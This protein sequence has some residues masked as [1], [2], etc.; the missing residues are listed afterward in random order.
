MTESSVRLPDASRLD[1][2]LDRLVTS[3][4]LTAD[5]AAAVRGEFDAAAGVNAPSTADRQPIGAAG[6]PPSWRAILPEVGGYVGAAFVVAATVVLVG[7]HWDDLSEAG[8]VLLFALPAALLIGAG[9]LIARSAPGGWTRHAGPVAA[10]RRR[11]VA[12][13]LTFGA[14]LGAG[15]V[16]VAAGPDGMDRAVFTS[17]AVLLLGAYLF[18]RSALIHL[19]ALLAVTFTTVSWTAWWAF[20]RWDLDNPSL[21]V[22]L[23]LGA[24]AAG[25]AAVSVTGGFDERRLGL[26]GAYAV[27]Y[28]AAQ[29][30]AVGSESSLVATLGYLGLVGLAVCGFVGYVRSKFVGHLVVGVVALAT[31][32]PEAVLDYTDGAFGAGGA[33][34]LVGLSI[35]GASMLGF[36]VHQH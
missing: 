17:A 11:V 19:A 1:V 12:V 16:G 33:L 22:G 36:R 9:V 5:Q 18:C 7:P 29:T 13:L 25:W 2:A 32:V 14:G 21:A 24:V 26:M 4:Q 8:Q 15:A 3:G 23:A 31:V 28:A 30:V 27:G 34:L 6:Q 35:V 10:G 20:E